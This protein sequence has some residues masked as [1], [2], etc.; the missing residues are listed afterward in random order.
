MNTFGSMDNIN[1]G[2]SYTP[3]WRLLR[4]RR[5]KTRH[6]R[7][8]PLFSEKRTHG[9]GGECP[10]PWGSH[11]GEHVSGCRWS[12]GSGRQRR[13]P[14]K[15]N[16]M[17]LFGTTSTGSD[18]TLP[19]WSPYAKNHSTV[20]LVTTPSTRHLRKFWT[21]HLTNHST[22]TRPPRRSCKSAR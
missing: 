8:W 4:R 21:G 10:M 2:N 9:S 19:S 6:T 17:R 1:G 7:S 11:K 18:S 5:T 15:R 14:A 3:A 16:C 12:K 22:L 20:P 13:K